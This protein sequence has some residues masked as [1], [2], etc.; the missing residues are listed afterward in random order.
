[1]V[2]IEE[3]DLRRLIAEE[4]QNA[5]A[6]VAAVKPFEPLYD[7]QD[8][9]LLLGTTRKSLQS[10]HRAGTSAIVAIGGRRYV[11]GESLARKVREAEIGARQRRTKQPTNNF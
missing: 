3:Q 2:V 1:M 4:M 9:A 8:A 6:A 11:T 5:T 7:I 10:W